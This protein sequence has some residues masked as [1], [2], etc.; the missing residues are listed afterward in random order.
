LPIEKGMD[1]AYRLALQPDGR[2]VA[3]GTNGKALIVRVRPNGQLDRSFGQGGMLEAWRNGWASA[4][5]IDRPGRIV[6][7]GG[8]WAAPP[9]IARYLAY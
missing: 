4:V 5:T 2:I 6:V 3:V 8:R 9:I 7:A 1:Y